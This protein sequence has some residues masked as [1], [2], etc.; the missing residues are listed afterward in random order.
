MGK[1][2]QQRTIE[3]LS[4]TLGY[5]KFNQEP[6]KSWG[7]L[8]RAAAFTYLAPTLCVGI[9]AVVVV[10]AVSVFPFIQRIFH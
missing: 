1:S 4:Y 5:R 10:V 8:G 3:G 7:E 2:Y 9:P 6:C